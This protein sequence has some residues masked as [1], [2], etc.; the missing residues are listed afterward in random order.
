LV[1]NGGGGPEAMSAG[2]IRMGG[3]LRSRSTADA[4]SGHPFSTKSLHNSESAWTNFG[5]F[6][7]LAKQWVVS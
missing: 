6:N 1:L 4:K 5:N 7:E 2:F 3:R